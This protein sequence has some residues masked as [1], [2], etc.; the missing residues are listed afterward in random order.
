MITGD[1]MPEQNSSSDAF[2]GL[3]AAIVLIAFVVVAA[4][5]SYVVLGAGFYTSQKSQETVYKSVEQATSNIQMVGN[6]YG[7]GSASS[8]I[9]TIMFSIALTPGA[10]TADLTKMTV[11][12]SSDTVTP[13]KYT[14]GG[15][16]ADASQHTFSAILSGTTTVVPAME[17]NDQVTIRINLASSDVLHA[18]NRYNLE[19]RPVKGAAYTF[20]RMSG[21]TL[22][23]TNIL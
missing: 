7:L 18:N 4:V 6:V 23:T 17:Q 8:G 13:V 16:T 10:P 11:I 21:P 3:E 20:T 15:A 22:S 12:Y 1:L 2:T 14:Y 5:F 19:V 9:T